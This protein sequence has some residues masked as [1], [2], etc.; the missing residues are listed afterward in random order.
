MPG[1]PVIFIVKWENDGVGLAL[2]DSCYSHMVERAVIIIMNSE[3]QWLTTGQFPSR[4]L[5]QV[6]YGPIAV[7][8]TVL[9]DRSR[10]KKQPRV[11]EKSGSEQGLPASPFL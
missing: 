5:G 6:R 11:Q 1:S 7:Y 8:H 9:L 2:I 10:T 3:Q 4:C